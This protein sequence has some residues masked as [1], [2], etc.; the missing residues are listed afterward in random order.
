[1]SLSPLLF[2]VSN[3]IIITI[4]FLTLAAMISN[5]ITSIPQHA[6]IGPIHHSGCTALFEPCHHHLQQDALPYYNTQLTNRILSV[7]VKTWSFPKSHLLCNFCK[8]SL[9][10]FFTMSC[11]LQSW[12]Q[13]VRYDHKVFVCGSDCGCY[14]GVKCPLN[15]S[16]T[17]ISH[18]HT[19]ANQS[20]ISSLVIQSF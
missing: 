6:I 15:A 5:H 16:E 10:G 8:W 3:L 20:F 7:R 2:I 19:P 13:P 17:S 11:H 1:M 4:I 18:F 14:F 12:G 9:N